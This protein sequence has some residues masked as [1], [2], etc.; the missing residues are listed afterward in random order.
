MGRISCA[1]LLDG[2]APSL[3][4]VFAHTSNCI[5]VVKGTHVIVYGLSLPPVRLPSKPSKNSNNINIY[6]LMIYKVYQLCKYSIVL[7]EY[8]WVWYILAS[9]P[10]VVTDNINLTHTYIETNNFIL[11]LQI[12]LFKFLSEFQLTE[13]GLIAYLKIVEM[14]IEI[15][16]LL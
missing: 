11:S 1:T 6:G 5:F 3:S 9:C 10:C 7:K 14:K 13:R 12:E 15:H 2:P 16:I 4:L 8:L